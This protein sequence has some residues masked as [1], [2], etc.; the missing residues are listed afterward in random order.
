M[1]KKV[2]D[3]EDEF[4]FFRLVIYYFEQSSGCSQAQIF[5]SSLNS[6]SKLHKQEFVRGQ[7]WMYICK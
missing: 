4:L 1:G 3:T 6:I 7:L 2:K 5:E